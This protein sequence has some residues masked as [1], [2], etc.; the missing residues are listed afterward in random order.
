M[1]SRQNE[2]AWDWSRLKDDSPAV[3]AKA[4]ALL[5]QTPWMARM[6]P[7]QHRLKAL[8]AG[9]AGWS[10]KV[11][12]WSAAKMERSYHEILLYGLVLAWGTEVTSF[13]LSAGGCE[14]PSRST[15]AL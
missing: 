14:R 3:K 1:S 2:G 15:T 5:I 8:M 10:T 13:D 11:G 7:H 9:A 6:V 12:P 4:W